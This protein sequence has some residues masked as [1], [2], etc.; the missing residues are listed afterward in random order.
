M[1][2]D[3]TYP[4]IQVVDLVA[5][6]VNLRVDGPQSEPKADEGH[7]QHTNVPNGHPRNR[8]RPNRSVPTS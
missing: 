2:F 1:R 5:Q 4:I 6:Y 3:P 7:A 8:L